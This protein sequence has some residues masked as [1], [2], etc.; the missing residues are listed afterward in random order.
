LASGYLTGKYRSAEDKS[1]SVRGGRMD[2][3]MAGK[4]PAVVAAMDAVSARTGASLAQIALAWQL[5]KPGI[6]APIASA[7]SVPQLNEL[8]GALEVKLSAEDVAALDAASA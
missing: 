5:V 4:G 6:A 2:K 1:K 8:M 3:Y 7:T